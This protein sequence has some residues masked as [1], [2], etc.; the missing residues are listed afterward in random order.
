MREKCW[1]NTRGQKIEI[2]YDLAM[3]YTLGEWHSIN[4]ASY[5]DL[6]NGIVLNA[7]STKRR[8]KKKT[9]KRFDCWAAVGYYFKSDLVFYDLPG[10]TNGKMSLK[11]YLYRDQI[12]EHVGEPWLFEGKD[13]VLEED[14]DS[15]DGKAQNR[16]IVRVWKSEKISNTFSTMP[17]L[18]IFPLLRIAGCPPKAT[19]SELSALG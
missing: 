18:Q 1:K 4:Y 5:V 3:K 6:V 11:V 16:N 10:N 19:P 7:F 15:G 14:S 9:K 17:L 2:E 12:L 13:F 8:L